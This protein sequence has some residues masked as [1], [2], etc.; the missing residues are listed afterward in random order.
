VALAVYFLFNW[1][2]ELVLSQARVRQLFSS[3][4]IVDVLTSVPVLVA[5][6][7]GQSISSINFLRLY[8]LLGITRVLRPIRLHRLAKISPGEDAVQVQMIRLGGYLLST[9]FLATGLVQA[10]ADNDAAAWK[11]TTEL[12]TRMAFHDA[13][14]YIVITFSTG[15]FLCEKFVIRATA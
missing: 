4:A 3:Q 12:G 7:A 10:L 1:M 9:V 15:E 6:F 13:L 2:L 8:R 11:S 5:V 14:Y